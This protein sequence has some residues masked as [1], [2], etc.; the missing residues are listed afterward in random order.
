MDENDK[1]IEIVVSLDID[2]FIRDA[3]ISCE[4]NPFEIEN[5]IGQQ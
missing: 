1:Y 3:Q 2:T 4:D 5:Y